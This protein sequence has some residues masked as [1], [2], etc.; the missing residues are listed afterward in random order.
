MPRESWPFRVL[1][2]DMSNDF[3]LSA[4]YAAADSVATRSKD[5]RP[6]SSTSRFRSY[7]WLEI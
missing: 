4:L 5:P 6:L 2:R 7:Q 3:L 1:A